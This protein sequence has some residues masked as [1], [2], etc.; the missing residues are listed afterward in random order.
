MAPNKS[1]AQVIAEQRGT[2]AISAPYIDPA[3]SEPNLDD[4][5]RIDRSLPKPVGRTVRHRSDA[6]LGRR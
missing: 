2:R 6:G 1:L 4:K 3:R 5:D